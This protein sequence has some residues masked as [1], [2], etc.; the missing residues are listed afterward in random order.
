[1]FGIRTPSL[2]KNAPI[3]TREWLKNSLYRYALGILI[4]AAVMALTP[5][6]LFDRLERIAYDLRLRLTL[7]HTPHPD[8]VIADID[9]AALQTLGRWPWRR[10]KMAALTDT[11]FGHYMIGALGF[12]VV[13]AEADESSGKR[14]LSE[15][16]RG[17]LREDPELSAL[18]SRVGPYM[19]LDGQFAKALQ[20][21]PTVLG[22]PFDTTAGA[23]SKSSGK[24][25]ASRVD[26]KLAAWMSGTVPQAKS[27]AANLPVLQEAAAG[28]GHI[29]PKVDLDGV[30][31][32][33]PIVIGYE[34]KL[35]EALSVALVRELLGAERLEPVFDNAPNPAQQPE[36]AGFNLVSPL[37]K[38]F[39]PTDEKGYALVPYRGPYHTFPYIS[40][41]DIIQRKAP[42][43]ALA[44]K[45]VIVGATAPGLLDLRAT[46]VANVFPGVEVHANLMAGILDKKIP[47]RPKYE[48]EF[49][50]AQMA[51]IG[52]LLTWLL[53]RMKPWRA[54][55]ITLAFTALLLLGNFMVWSRYAIAMPIIPTAT[56]IF[57]LLLGYMGWGY[58]VESASKRQFSALFGQ[59]VPPE[60]VEK[61]AEDPTKYSMEGR[62]AEL[63]VLFSDV[64]DFTS[65]SEK[66]DAKQ[67]SHLI[68]EYLTE[69]SDIIRSQFQGTLDKYI[70]DAIMCFWGA[71]VAQADH[72][73]RAVLA[74]LAMHRRMREMAPRLIAEYG[75]PL[76]IGVGVNS[77]QMTVGD[78]GSNIRR[79]YTVMGDNVN[80]G[81][82]LEGLTKNYGVG[83]M[84]SESTRAATPEIA[85]RELDRVRV[86][87]KQIPIAVFEPV[88][89]WDEVSDEIK[90]RLS[91]W[92]RALEAYLQQDW[93][94]AEAL[95][96]PLIGA[97]LWH[98]EDYLYT[99]YLA[100]IA[101]YR[102]EPPPAEWDGVTTFTTK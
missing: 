16:S 96:T 33:V 51:L 95:L 8:I 101:H 6:G 24:L 82:R 71:P 17:A 34:S 84:V 66:L 44:G 2:P 10:D 61:M 46:P 7:T 80:L 69:M 30:I 35:Y 64:R 76:H 20:D 5:T 9:E 41:A 42:V 12:D 54:W 29:N 48:K 102:S 36:L 79:A 74:A 18:L 38:W 32:S 45:I 92:Q 50:L 73:R 85:Y 56:L 57:S 62:N 60:L 90:A 59:Y 25:P 89:L 98:N 43:D 72:A 70:G 15:L 68:N 27:F 99:L 39:I 14:Y 58:L 86:K 81:S 28:G 75:F 100:R 13:F 97:S 78:M 83:V 63:S 88:G 55:G 49:D 87:G 21:K 94:A 91:L 1:M 22:Y 53:P 26:E 37:G 31:R 47:L 93:D 67:L 65:I 23:H 19:D 4:T 40:I 3:A 52:L 77:G 11:L